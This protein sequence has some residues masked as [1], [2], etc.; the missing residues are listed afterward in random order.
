MK[1]H[2][3]PKQGDNFDKKYCLQS[4][5]LGTETLERYKEITLEP[6][7][8]KIFK[9]FDCDKVPDELKVPEPKIK[10][11]DSS[12]NGN[13]VC[14]SSNNS[15]VSVSRNI[16]LKVNNP[17]VKKGGNNSK[18]VNQRNN[19]MGNTLIN[20]NQI[21]HENNNNKQMT[22]QIPAMNIIVKEQNEIFEKEQNSKDEENNL[23]FTHELKFDIDKKKEQKINFTKNPENSIMINK[24]NFSTVNEKKKIFR[25]LGDGEVPKNHNIHKYIQYISF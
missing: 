2:Y 7:Y 15:T 20:R 24:K 19:S 3:I 4:N 5:K 16:K 23:K 25:L 17:E 22:K 10:A 13:G 9:K 14:N 21:I 1:A 12:N 11:A 8:G 18:T 6:N